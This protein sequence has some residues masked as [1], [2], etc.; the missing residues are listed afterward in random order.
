MSAYCA[1]VLPTPETVDVTVM[2]KLPTVVEYVVPIES[3]N[4]APGTDS[5]IG[6][7]PTVGVAPLGR[8]ETVIVALPLEPLASP[9]MWMDAPCVIVLD[10]EF[11]DTEIKPKLA[12]TVPDPSISTVVGDND[13]LEMVSADVALHEARKYGLIPVALI[14]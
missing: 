11:S 7:L 4:W 14:V 5:V 12:V 8:P 6:L 1:E 3:E 10:P 9:E 13:G 2:V